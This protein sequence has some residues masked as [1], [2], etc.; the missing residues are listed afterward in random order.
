MDDVLEVGLAKNPAIRTK[1]VG[2]LADAV[3]AAYG[4]AGNHLEWAVAPQQDLAARIAEAAPR[5][6]A[7]KVA[8]LGVAA[9]PFAADPF[10]AP[11]PAYGGGAPSPDRGMSQAFAAVREAELAPAG[12]PG[13]KPGWLL[14]L[15]VGVLALLV[16][17][18]VTLVVMMGR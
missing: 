16:G 4:L 2:A 8:P 10:A 12:L 15:I 6:M 5:V 14:P 3:G 9:D 18:A 1:S 7:A 17:G 11:G 13:G